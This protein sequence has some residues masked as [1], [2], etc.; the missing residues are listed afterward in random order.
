MKYCAINGEIVTNLA[1]NDRGLAYGDG[2]FTTAKIVSGRVELLK[3]HVIRLVDGC[4]K[5]AIP[6]PLL[7]TQDELTNQLSSTAKDYSL[8]VLKVIITAGSGGRG[9][10]RQGLNHD[11]SNIIV[12][13]FDYPA[14]YDELAKSGINIGISQ[15][16]ISISPMLAGI[17]HL[18]RLEQVLLRRELDNREEDDLVVMNINEQ[19]IEATSANLFY[20]LNGDLCTPDVKVSGVDGLM[21]QFIMANYSK[22]Y[23]REV[24]VLATTLVQLE[25]ASAMFTCNSVTGVI[26]VRCFN[27]RLLNLEPAQT[28]RL[29]IQELIGD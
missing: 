1:I 18:N 14:H 27:N 28:L 22:Y 21:R 10:S 6:L 7:L 9:Y 12:M 25:Q 4:S 15:Q 2:L 13:V 19:V 3:Q 16:K 26:P 5:L 24:N 29:K 11:A 8:A 23:K 17:K 20:W